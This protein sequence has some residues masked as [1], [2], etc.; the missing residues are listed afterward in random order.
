M[1]MSEAPPP[2]AAPKPRRRWFQFSLRTLM[3]LMVVISVGLGFMGRKLQRV[4]EQRQT[5][6]AIQ[7]LGGV[8]AYTYPAS[9]FGGGSSDAPP[10]PAW[11]TKMLGDDFWGIVDDI[12]I[13]NDGGLT[14]D[15][16]EHLEGLHQLESLY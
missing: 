8:V 3:L 14:D 11:L 4:R 2:T 6:A 7:K 5:V 1:I 15:D 13:P 10:G 16:L 9:L 12:S